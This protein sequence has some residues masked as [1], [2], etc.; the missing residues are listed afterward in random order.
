VQAIFRDAKYP[1]GQQIADADMADLRIEPHA[2]CP[3]WNYTIYPRI[4]PRTDL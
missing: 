1:T 4:P 2:I 3:Q